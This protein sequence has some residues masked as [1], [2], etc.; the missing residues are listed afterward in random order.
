MKI[1]IF[2]IALNKGGAERVITNLCNEYLVQENQITIITCIKAQSQYLLDKRISRICLD[3]KKG[4]EKQN[5]IIRFIRRRK[6]LKRILKNMDADV[7]LN[8]LPEPSFLALSLKRKGGVPM[9]VSER[10]APEIEYAFWPYKIA[11]RLLYRKADGLIMQTEA[12]KSYFPKAIR[13]KSV[14]IPNPVNKAAMRKPFQGERKKEIVAVGRLTKEKNYFLLIDAFQRIC[15]S[16]PEYCLIIYGDGPLWDELEAYIK[17]RD[18]GSRVVLAGQKDDIF[19]WIYQSSLFVLSSSYEGLPNALM[20]AMALGLPVIATDCIGGGPRSLIKNGYNG[21][22]V[23]PEDSE[24]LGNAMSYVLSDQAFAKKL[25]ENA[26][27]LIMDLKPE[28]IYR[29]WGD[30]FSYIAGKKVERCRRF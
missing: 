27:K 14:V 17:T 19:D 15:G 9:I 29:Q 23:K 16:F 8:V 26:G 6:K 2:I 30:Y 13:D 7:L 11:M 25:G 21:L 24:C 3:E 4:D 5:Q 18:L 10:S 1:V 28:K 22:L 12:A 20:E